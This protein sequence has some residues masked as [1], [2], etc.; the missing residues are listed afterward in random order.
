M[1][2]SRPPPWLAGMLVRTWG[3]LMSRNGGVDGKGSI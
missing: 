2:V 3:K 1:M